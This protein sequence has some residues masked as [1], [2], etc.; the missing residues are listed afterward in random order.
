MAHLRR[1]NARALAAAY[2]EDAWTHLRRVPRLV[3]SALH[4]DHCEQ[5]VLKQVFGSLQESADVSST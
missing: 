1:W 4:L 3:R 2:L 5:P